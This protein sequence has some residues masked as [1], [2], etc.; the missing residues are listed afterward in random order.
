M[1]AQR[2]FRFM[3]TIVLQ[4]LCVRL[5]STEG[6]VKVITDIEREADLVVKDLKDKRLRAAKEETSRNAIKTSVHRSLSL[7]A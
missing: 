1:L 7:S 2:K 6:I 4:D 5:E 3:V